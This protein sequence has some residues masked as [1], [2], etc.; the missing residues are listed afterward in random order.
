MLDGLDPLT[1]AAG[2]A[3]PPP[4]ESDVRRPAGV[5]VP[6]AA[7]QSSGAL[8]GSVLSPQ[9]WK[10]TLAFLSGG[11]QSTSPRTEAG[12]LQRPAT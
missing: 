6:S 7:R 1:P 12:D 4:A 9:T 3:S 8:A 11:E 2:Q 10:Q 5:R